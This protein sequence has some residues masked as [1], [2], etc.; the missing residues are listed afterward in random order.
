MM[1]FANKLKV[2][3]KTHVTLTQLLWT[4]GRVKCTRQPGFLPGGFS[5]EK[6]CIDYLCLSGTSSRQSVSH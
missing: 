6:D 5:V 3:R 4:V 2:T 1:R